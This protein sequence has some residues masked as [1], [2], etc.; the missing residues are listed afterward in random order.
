MDDQ[1]FLAFLT[2][3]APACEV[4]TLR[5]AVDKLNEN[6]AGR[7]FGRPPGLEVGSH[8]EAVDLHGS[9]YRY[10]TVV[11]L[12]ENFCIIKP[13]VGRFTDR[14]SFKKQIVR[15][16]DEYEWN[17]VCFSAETQK[18][19]IDEETAR[20][21]AELAA[22]RQEVIAERD[23]AQRVVM[24]A[25]NGAVELFCGAY[26]YAYRP[27]WAMHEYGVVVDMTPKKIILSSP[28]CILGTE[29]IAVAKHEITLLDDR[30]WQRVD[31]ELRRRKAEWDE[32]A[33]SGTT[34][35]LPDYCRFEIDLA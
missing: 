7:V 27:D 18:K 13:P 8:V 2:N 14:I 23:T 24:E 17:R 32:A 26:V 30:Q 21:R 19:E 1:T 15:I 11:K 5:K 35:K 3:N 28:D 6:I 4:E 20:E 34:A 16:L 29:R 25:L 31:K 9:W 10:G 12:R 33:T 22:L